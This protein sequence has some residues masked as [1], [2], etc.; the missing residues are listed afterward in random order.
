MESREDRWPQTL[1]KLKGREI[2]EKLYQTTIPLSGRRLNRSKPRIRNGEDDI[3]AVDEQL[4]RCKELVGEILNRPS[5]TNPPTLQPGEEHMT[6]LRP[7]LDL[8][9]KAS[10]QIGKAA[11]VDNLLSETIHAG[12]VVP[13]SRPCTASKSGGKRK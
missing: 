10:N 13:Q 12:G 5:Q 11:G 8:S 9:L 4:A 1:R 6:S 3:L 7:K 2:S